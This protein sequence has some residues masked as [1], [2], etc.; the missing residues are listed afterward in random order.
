MDLKTPI[1]DA[2]LTFRMHARQLEKLGI[3]T[4]EDFLLYCPYRYEDL[5]VIS[6]IGDT[7]PGEKVTIQGKVFDTKAIFTKRHFNLQKVI[8]FDETG[9]IECT[10]FNQKYILTQIKKGNFVSVSGKVDSVGRTK[11]LLVT[12]YEILQ[13]E[14]DIS[15][16]TGRLVPV[17]SETRGL[18]SK[19]IRNR[20]RDLLEKHAKTINE[21][22]P[23]KLL[24]ENHLIKLSDA[25]S[26]IHFPVSLE[27]SESARE[28]LSF[29][30]LFLTQLGSKIRK[31]DW[32]TKKI[33]FPFEIEKFQADIQKFWENLPFELTGA[34]MRSIHE[35]LADLNSKTPMNRMLQG[36]VGSGKTVV[37]AVALYISYLNSFQS[38]FMAPTE[39]LANQHFETLERL[40]KPLGIKIALF[41]G[42]K[43]LNIAD[44]DIAVGTHALLQKTV[45]FKNLGLVIVDEQQRFGVEQRAILR[46]KSKNPHFLTMTATPIPRTVFLTLYGDLQLSFLDEMPHGRKIVK[47]WLVPEEKRTGGYEWIEKHIKEEKTQAFIVCPFIEESENMTTV[48]AAAKEFEYLSKEIFPHLKLGLL[49]GKMKSKEKDEVLEQFRQ[50]KTD[51][52]V[53]TPVVE[54]GIDIPNATIMLIEA[55]DRFGL[56]QLH[57]LRGRVGRSEEQSYCLL[58]TESKN[59]KTT[60][61]LKY[62]E[63]SHV[64]AE[65]A[66]LDLKL[67]GPGDMF[68]TLQHGKDGLKIASLS[69]FP[70]IEK[71]RLAAEKTF[72]NIESYPLLR[73][74]VESNIIHKVTPD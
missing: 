40:L 55:A 13:N 53:A 72:E 68:G 52:L 38:V 8:V 34:Q 28:R 4:V 74:K 41:T 14:N 1:K 26:R 45:E 15:F 16:H 19:W 25:I 20:M 64:G 57:Q 10:W 36:D 12:D 51:I 66:E 3:T 6:K 39:I 9:E 67:R 7:Q 11:T 73:K 49:H 47:T 59:P 30:E 54:V 60:E 42:K 48:K 29:D 18:S 17:Y 23:E 58:F 46:E 44:F 43:K 65:L 61:R 2:G 56:A 62:L 32:E 71:T 21:Y 35:I 24:A 63:R 69:N 27:E 50:G 22:L 5:S 33:G 37:A 70:L 31:K